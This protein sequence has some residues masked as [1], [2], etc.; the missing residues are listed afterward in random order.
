[1]SRRSSVLSKAFAILVLF[2]VMFF[3]GIAF[4]VSAQSIWACAILS[5]VPPV[6]VCLF[7]TKD[8]Y[9]IIS[10]ILLFVSQQAIFV[11]VNPSWGFSFGSD[12]IN[13]F[14]IASVMSTTPHFE[15]GHLGYVG[16]TSYSY[17]PMVHL[18]SVLFSDV[19]AIPLGT[20]ALYSVPFLNAFLVTI[21]LFYLNSG[22]FGL[23]GRERNIA[24]LLFEVSFYYTAF[25]SQFIRETFAFPFV[26]LAILLLYR[27]TKSNNRSYSLMILLL[28]IVI[29]LSHQ[30][31]SYLFVAILALMALAFTFFNRNNRTN[32]LALFGAVA[33]AAYTFF[34]ALSFSSTQWTMTLH[35]L[36]AL[37]VRK[38]STTIMASSS[39]VSFYL[40]MIYY[41]ILVMLIF[42]GGVKLLKEKRKNRAVL[43]ILA[44][45]TIMFILSVLLRLS[46]SADPWSWT[47]YMGLRGTIWAFIGVSVLATVGLAWILKIARGGKTT[48]I[49]LVILISLLAAGKLSQFGPNFAN[50][51]GQPVTYTRY[52]AASWLKGVTVHGSNMLVAP[53]Q[54]DMAGFEAARDMAPYAYLTEYFVDE[55]H[56]PYFSQF[57]GYVAFVGSYYDQYA[58]ST[59]IQIVYNNGLVEVGSKGR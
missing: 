41:A 12:T 5:F 2:Q 1:M 55:V 51:A 20:V 40:S 3:V 49:V 59:K 30:V 11:F 10:L 7:Y 34:V 8:K 14:H 57:D 21:A 44:F 15:L 58:N 4:Q 22:L 52:V 32:A 27:T 31:T 16:R 56:G 9:V 28:A 29:T 24:T 43:A 35:G 18:F 45:F 53:F 38:G 47:Y 23:Q 37:F 19:S 13:D 46:T 42:V 6:F 26:L 50:P 39:R 25:Q 36:Q 17:F 48:M 33:L 54:V